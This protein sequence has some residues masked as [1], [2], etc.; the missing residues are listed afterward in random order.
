MSKGFKRLVLGISAAVVVFV[1]LGGSANLTGV[2]ADTSGNSDGAYRQ[3]GVYEE[4]LKKV[5]SDYVVEPNMNEVSDGALHGMLESLDSDSSYLTKTEYK[6]Y[7]DHLGAE[8][9]AAQVGLVV[10]KRF[11]YAT[12]ITV[13]PDSPAE[14]AEIEDG[15]IL[16]SIEGV[17]TR[18]MSLAMIRVLLEGKPGS[19]VTFSL[20]VSSPRK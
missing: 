13:V 15:D 17:S 18:E 4:V 7:K 12:V 9:N 5:Q 2:R 8:K 20:P 16:E 11:G 3:M 6:A 10:S 14:K 1:F 19:S